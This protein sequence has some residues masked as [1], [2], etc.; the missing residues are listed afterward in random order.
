VTDIGYQVNR[1]DESNNLATVVLGLTTLLDELADSVEEPANR[2]AKSVTENDEL[3]VSAFLGM[4]SVRRTLNRWLDSIDCETVDLRESP[5]P[6]KSA[7]GR[8]LLR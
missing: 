7:D 6:S 3:I 1:S 5:V 4:L 8:G 2:D